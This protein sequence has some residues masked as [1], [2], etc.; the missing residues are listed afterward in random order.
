[1]KTLLTILLLTATSTWTFA[2]IPDVVTLKEARRDHLL[3]YSPSPKYPDE[4]ARRG[5]VGTADFELTFDYESGHLRE[6][7]LLKSFGSA[8][9]D[10]S[11]I[12][13]LKEWKAKPRSIHRLLVPLG[14]ATRE[15][16]PKT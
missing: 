13:A 14:F 1:M 15:H 11:A 2:S 7:H 4:V 8:V 3:L 16:W 5:V 6:V 9:L 12:A 10:A